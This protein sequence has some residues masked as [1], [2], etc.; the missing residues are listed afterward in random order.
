MGMSEKRL[1]ALEI[2]LESNG[3]ATNKYI[4][5]AVDAPQNTVSAW[6]CRDNWMSRLEHHQQ[7]KIY[8]ADDARNR[9][10][11]QGKYHDNHKHGIYSSIQ[12][13]RLSDEERDILTFIDMDNDP[14][15]PLR[16]Q[17]MAT[18]VQ[19]QRIYDMIAEL[20]ERRPKDYIDSIIRLEGEA[21]KKTQASAKLLDTIMKAQE[22]TGEN[23]DIEDRSWLHAM[24][25]GKKHENMD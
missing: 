9:E 15:F 4:A 11:K 2:F 6:K 3:R 5:K 10:K 12:W 7:G 17:Y 20:S 19:L 24:I 16:E 25:E 21:N 23:A 13:L 18:L 22:Q 8:E 14:L 1:V